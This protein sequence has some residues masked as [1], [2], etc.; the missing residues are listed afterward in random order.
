MESDFADALAK[1]AAHMNKV[2]GRL[3]QA[4][5]LRE[6]VVIPGINE[7][8]YAGRRFIDAWAICA[9]PAPTEKQQQE[10]RDHIVVA[11]QYLQNA[12][13]DVTDAVCFF[14]HREINRMQRA[15]GA[16][17]MIRVFPRY[18]E[19]A[20]QMR[21]ANEI[22][23]GSR[24]TRQQRTAEYARLEADYIPS[25]IQTFEQLRFS[26]TLALAGAKRKRFR[27]NALV[28]IGAA[29]GLYALWQ[30]IHAAWAYVAAA[31]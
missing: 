27:E 6:E 13:H 7:L 1:L 26:E 25:L 30:P 29:A 21:T 5:Q 9:L 11:R 22:I 18:A 16:N 19:F 24:E 10:A 2:E 23:S 4:E 31:L 28:A 17:E 14:I 3:K 15:Y 20:Q 8:R 12:D